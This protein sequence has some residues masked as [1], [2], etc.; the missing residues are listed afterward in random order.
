MLLLC[1][2]VT[3]LMFCL[4]QNKDNF[5][6]MNF[7]YYVTFVKKSI[8]FLIS[9]Q[10]ILNSTTI[11]ELNIR[12]NYWNLKNQNYPTFSRRKVGVLL[13]FDKV[14]LGNVSDDAIFIKS[15]IKCD[16]NKLQTYKL[17]NFE[18]ISFCILVCQVPNTFIN[19]YL[20]HKY[21]KSSS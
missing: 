13:I 1:Y 3:Y 12:I 9:L 14:S 19:D 4:M 18:Y 2:I 15:D 10:R 21:L 16:N 11:L 17:E 6:I 7:V 20:Y 8:C 5:V